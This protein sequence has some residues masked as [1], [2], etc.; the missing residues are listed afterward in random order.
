MYKQQRRPRGQQVWQQEAWLPRH[1]IQ[2]MVDFVCFHVK[3]GPNLLSAL[4]AAVVPLF[5]RGVLVHRHT[6]G[7]R[8]IPQVPCGLLLTLFGPP[9]HENRTAPY[10][11]FPGRSR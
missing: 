4:Q 11:T 2:R 1:A 9:P 5:V 6:T 8:A 3:E 10:C 7:C